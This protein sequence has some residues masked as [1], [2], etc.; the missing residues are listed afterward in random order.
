MRFWFLPALAL[1]V[2][3]AGCMTAEERRAA[4]EERCRSYGF[5]Q[6]NDAFAECMQR[7]DLARRARFDNRPYVDTFQPRVIVVN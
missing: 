1:V 4:D 5:K 6:R 2:L 3:L 7:I